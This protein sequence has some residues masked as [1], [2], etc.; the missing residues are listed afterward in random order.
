MKTTIKTTVLGIA[1][2]LPLLVSAEVARPKAGVIKDL[3]QDLKEKRMEIATSTEARIEKR[4]ERRETLLKIAGLKLQNMINRFTDTLSRLDSI[5][6]K[7]ISRIEKVKSNGGNTSEAEKYIAEAQKHFSDA[8]I[9]LTK[10]ESA[11][12]TAK[13]LL[14]DSNTSTS[15]IIK[16]GLK[17]IKDL[18]LSVESDIKAGHKSL[19]NALKS[20]RGMSGTNATTTKSN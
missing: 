8:K 18:A 11:T 6:N 10:L 16:T 15:T 2:L 4:D 1:I 3:R 14:V 9:S 17:K 20:L 5:T 12:S 7:I 19:N 13:E